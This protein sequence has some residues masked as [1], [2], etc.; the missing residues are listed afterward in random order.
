MTTI[1]TPKI[2]TRPEQVYIGIRTVTPFSG[3]FKVVTQIN[4]Q[5]HRWLRDHQVTPAGPPFLRYNV[6]D[7]NGPMDITFGVPV[8]AA[9]TEE[10]HVTVGKLLAGTYA[11]LIYTGSGLAGNKALID[12]V[13]QNGLIFDRWPS[14][15]GDNF[16][17]RYEAF[18]TDPKVEPRKTR[19]E[20]EVA[21]KLQDAPRAD[22]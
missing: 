19:W 4:K 18:L 9:M 8:E 16:A 11:S 15:Q 10:G 5:L 22:G 17:C 7:M 20:V 14:E 21:I 1:G 6:I 13:R 3:M 2:D 12:W